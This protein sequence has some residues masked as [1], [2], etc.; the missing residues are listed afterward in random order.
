LK[1]NPFKLKAIVET[2]IAVSQIQT[3]GHAA[4][5]KCKDLELLNDAYWKIKR[6]K[7]P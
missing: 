3:T 5:K 6:P 7:Y 4:R 1:F 2:P